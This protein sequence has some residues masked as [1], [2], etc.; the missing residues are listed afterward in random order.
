MGASDDEGR[1]FAAAF[2]GFME[3]VGATGGQ[4]GAGAVVDLV[5]AHLAR[6]WTNLSVVSRELP[7]F[8]HVN[9]QTALASWSEQDG[10][11]VRVQGFSIPPHYAVPTL[12]QLLSGEGL[13][14][15][16]LSA[17]DLVDLPSGPGG[18]TLACYQRAMLLVEDRSGRYVVL[19]SAPERHQEPALT[20]EVAGL[21]VA[22]AQQVHAD[23]ARLRSE[24]NV[25]R[26]Q[27]LDLT[28]GQMGGLQLSFADLPTTTRSDV[29]LPEDV[30]RRIE[31]HTVDIAAHRQDLLD[32]GQH[33]KRGLLLFGPPG[34]G[35]THTTRYVVGRL[36]GCTVLLLAGNALHLVGAVAE[37]AREL[38]P[39]VLVLEDVDL[40]AEDRG[41]GPGSNPVLFELLD[42][43]DGAAADAD[44]LFL[45]TTNRA[46]LLEPALAARPGRVDIAVEIDL[47]DGDARRRLFELYSRGVPLTLAAED[48]DRVVTRTEGTTASF[49]KELV[50]RAVLESLSASS[51]L[52]DVTATHVD[53]ALDDLLDSSQHI[54]RALLGAGG[55][56]KDGDAGF[57]GRAAGG[58]G[59][60]VGYRAMPGVY[61]G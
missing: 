38:Q 31:R 36:R 5:R 23:L 27:V 52:T 17:P 20:V 57:T 39:T 26:G 60:M 24:L 35:K 1:Q 34:T 4:D 28:T 58:H 33:L 47:P 9:L 32:A 43:M 45:L 48:V 55:S 54:T 2:R 8:E 15:M 18:Q 22:A 49:L 46:D 3:W 16:R 40:V 51:P 44:L 37:M 6:D 50:R 21:D 11:S 29:V 13:A 12:Q 19:V 7:P 30:L 14:P 61:R 56:S 41:F 10:R 42:T 25:Y 59:G 53:A